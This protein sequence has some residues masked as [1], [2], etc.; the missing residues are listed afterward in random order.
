M[1]FVALSFIIIYSLAT[2]GAVQPHDS[3]LVPICLVLVLDGY[4]VAA[5]LLRGRWHYVLVLVLSSAVLSPAAVRSVFFIGLTAALLGWAAATEGRAQI[6]RFFRVLVVIGVV[7]AVLGLTQYFISPGWIFGYINTAYPVSGSLIN[8]NH[9]AGLL[10][11]LAPVA[12]GLAYHSAMRFADLA[13]T[14][15]YL[16]AAAVMGLALLLSISRMG[17]VSFF[18]TLFFLAILMRIRQSGRRIAAGFTFTILGLALAAV[19]WVGIDAILQPYSL[20]LGEEAILREGRLLVY[21]DTIRMIRTNP[22]GVGIGNFQ[23]RFREYQTYRPALLFDHAHNDYLETA[24]EWGIPLAMVFWTLILVA[25]I[26]SICLFVST[27]SHEYRGVLLACI[28]AVF[29]ILIHSLTDFNLQIPSNAILFFT[30]V[31]ICLALPI[32]NGEK[33][34][35]RAT[36]LPKPI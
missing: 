9:F 29:S 15:M 32:R 21:R 1:L 28:G 24:A 7:E 12:I 17:I 30:F 14:Y 23:D 31:G 34:M 13:R 20:L 5:A 19:L 25:F 18:T 10:E 36:A 2:F 11:M 33:D 16:L 8:H 3:L 4:M 26:R 22:L 35:D 27:H 6:F